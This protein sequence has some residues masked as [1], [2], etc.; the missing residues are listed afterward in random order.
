[1]RH[2]EIINDLHILPVF[3]WMVLLKNQLHSE[4]CKHCL[5]CG[6]VRKD[7]QD[8]HVILLQFLTQDPIFFRFVFCIYNIIQYDIEKN[9]KIPYHLLMLLPINLL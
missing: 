6:I 1:M 4:L 5:T 9:K 8:G 3:C 7:K 2:A